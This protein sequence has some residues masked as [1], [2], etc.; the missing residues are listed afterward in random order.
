MGGTCGRM[1]VSMENRCCSVLLLHIKRLL[2]AKINGTQ[3]K[4]R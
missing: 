1:M 3:R 2:S 4:T